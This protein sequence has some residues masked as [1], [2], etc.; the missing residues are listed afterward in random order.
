MTDQRS[1]PT[2]LTNAICNTCKAVT[3]H[4]HG[5]CIACTRFALDPRC[6]SGTRHAKERG[7]DVVPQWTLNDEHRSDIEKNAE[8]SW[9]D[10]AWNCRIYAT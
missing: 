10:D 4:Q 8:A 6:F 9:D 7:W 5:D 2:G 1:A 3:T